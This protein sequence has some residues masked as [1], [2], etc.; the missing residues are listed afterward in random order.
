MAPR[1]HSEEIA[2][3]FGGNWM[4]VFREAWNSE[5]H[6]LFD[7]QLRSAAFESDSVRLV[8]NRRWPIPG[9]QRVRIWLVACSAI[10]F[11]LRPVADDRRS[12]RNCSESTLLQGSDRY[13]RMG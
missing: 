6:R 2:K 5:F 8:I 3:V 1:L 12:A 4:R 10:P 11:F 7:R 13:R 9:G